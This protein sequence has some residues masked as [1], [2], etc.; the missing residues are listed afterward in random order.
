MSHLETEVKAASEW[1]LPAHLF[2][3]SSH[4]SKRKKSEYVHENYEF[5][6]GIILNYL[7]SPRHEIPWF[8][9]KKKRAATTAVKGEEGVPAGFPAWDQGQIW[10]WF[11][12]SSIMVLW[13][14]LMLMKIIINNNQ[15]STIN[16]QQSTI[17]NQQSTVNNQK[18]IINDQ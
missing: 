13:S 7:E 10:S 2:G 16:S 12:Q 1:P 11:G 6:T 14:G 18:S 9:P 8:S 3:K 17:N 15:Q 4:S 5:Q